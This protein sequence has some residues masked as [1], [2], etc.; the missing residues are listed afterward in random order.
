[1]PNHKKPTA[2]HLLNGNPGHRPLNLDEPEF[3]ES[4]AQPPEEVLQDPI[5]LQEWQRR[6]PELIEQGLLCRQYETEFAEYCKQHSL[7]QRI[8][9]EIN[10]RGIDDAIAAG[11][12]K[13]FQAAVTQRLRIAAK[14]GFTP[15]D[16]TGVKAKPKEKPKGAARF[17]T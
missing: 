3:Q 11:L 7:A 5:A 15:S 1:M 14:F 6:A 10:A 13:H 12:L 17:L 2:L 4:E 9:R 16:V 8:W